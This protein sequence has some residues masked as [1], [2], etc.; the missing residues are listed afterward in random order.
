VNSDT[1]PINLPRVLFVGRTTL[2]LI[3]SL[4]RFPAEDTKA[5]ARAMH[6][7]PGG[8]AA[9][10]AITHALLGGRAKLLTAI[11]RGS[12]ASPVRDELQ[13]LGIDLIDLAAETSYETPLTTVLASE[14]GA[15]RT[16]V[17]PPASNAELR[18][19]QTWDAVWGEAPSL[20]LA[21]GFHLDVTLPLLR[22]LRLGGAQLCFDGGS[23]KR[24]TEELASLL[25]VAICSER[26]QVPGRQADPDSTIN[27]FADRG[28][29]HIAVSRGAK[30]IICRDRGRTFE[31]Q[32]ARIDA[33]DTTGAGDV[34]H[35]AFCNHFV[36]RED[37]EQAL[38]FAAAIA[39]R[40]CQEL[41]IHGWAKNR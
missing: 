31:I 5:F 22:E 18:T 21:D 29:P 36:Q 30:P 13:R 6:V 11:G 41:G 10:A 32:I 33:A 7:A 35:G 19:I 1:D 16:I 12:W 39:T 25:S 28:V 4:D 20:V 9:N 27:W 14:A 17:N 15:T 3:Y 24:G 8:P 38:R 37:F 26:F 2:D 34:L 23:W 40:S